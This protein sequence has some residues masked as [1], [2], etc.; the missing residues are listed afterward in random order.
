MDFTLADIEKLLQRELKKELD[1][2]KS[3]IDTMEITLDLMSKNTQDL[4]QEVFIIRHVQL[5]RLTRAV[6]AIAH[7][8]G[9]MSSDIQ[10]LEAAI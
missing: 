10:E 3:R 4:K 8:A 2:I 7:H 1:P 6:V 9:V 5:P